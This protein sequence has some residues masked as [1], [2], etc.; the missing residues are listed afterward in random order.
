VTVSLFGE[1]NDS[2]DIA[3]RQILGLRYLRGIQPLFRSVLGQ[4]EAS[5]A[6]P[7]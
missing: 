6:P 7:S 2:L 4:M 1:I 3:R 5:M